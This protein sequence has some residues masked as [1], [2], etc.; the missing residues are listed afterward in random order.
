MASIARCHHRCWAGGGGGAGHHSGGRGGGGGARRR[1]KWCRRSARRRP[2]GA[3]AGQPV[4]E[5]RVQQ[6]VMG[7]EAAAMTTAREHQ[8]RRA[9]PHSTPTATAADARPRLGNHVLVQQVARQTT[10]LSSVAP[11][12]SAP[13]SSSAW[14]GFFAVVMRCSSPTATGNSRC[15]SSHQL[16]KCNFKIFNTL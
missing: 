7:D 16:H 2:A 9:F 5:A 12:D 15:E 1:R 11:S 8:S 3:R 14:L 6:L 4:G 10:R 13:P